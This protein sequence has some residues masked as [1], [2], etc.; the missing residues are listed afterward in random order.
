MSITLFAKPKFQG[1]ASPIA[2][3]C[4]NLRRL[5]VGMR[6]SSITM[7]D[8]MD[9]VLLY[10]EPNWKGGAMYL[11][12]P[13]QL[14]DLERGRSVGQTPFRNAAESV[15][16]TPF[17]IP[18]NFHVVANDA[19][20]LAG[21]FADRWDLEATLRSTL[22]NLNDWHDQE[23]TLLRFEIAQFTVR[24]N[25]RHYDIKGFESFRF[26]HGWQSPVMV[27]VILVNTH[28]AA[29]GQAT[30]PGLG[31]TI[32]LALRDNDLGNVRP[33]TH[34]AGVLSHELGHY[35][36]SSHRSGGGSIENIMSKSSPLDIFQNKADPAQ[37]EEWHTTLAR[38]PMRCQDRRD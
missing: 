5:A 28:N 23:Q 9:A 32:V 36:S 11:R 21:G 31:N 10:R 27:D 13:Q 38:H 14:D 8:R 25:E 2:S 33:V 34:L 26:P 30:P 37:I 6:P 22:F 7:T 18:L 20:V 24:K 19:G 17:R 15:R 29:S 12:G 35:W 16:V 4:S 3:D 1:A